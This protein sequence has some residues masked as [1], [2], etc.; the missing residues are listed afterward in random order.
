MLGFFFF[1]FFFFFGLGTN[2]AHFAV[3]RVPTL[4]WA[5]MCIS[6]AHLLRQS[7]AAP[8][9][10]CYSS[11]IHRHRQQRT[12]LRQCALQSRSALVVRLRLPARRE[13][14]YP[15]R[16]CSC[17]NPFRGCGPRPNP[18]S[19]ADV[20]LDVPS[21]FGACPIVISPLW[22]PWASR[23]LP[24]SFGVSIPMRR[25]YSLSSL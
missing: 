7:G 6:R 15:C 5:S 8:E 2:K 3:F 1:F 23:R 24:R 22:R 25:M 21:T 14:C 20:P 12:I 18:S 10:W 16:L 19:N 4:R 17:Q 9:R 11:G 13:P